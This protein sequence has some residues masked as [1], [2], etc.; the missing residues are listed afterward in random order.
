MLAVITKI[1]P[2]EWERKK[3]HKIVN[4]FLENTRPKL[5]GLKIVLGGSFA[6]DTW[7]SGDHDIDLFVKF[8][9]NLYRKKNLS[10]LLAKRL[11]N[12]NLVHGSRDYFQVQYKGYLFELIPVLDIK[13]QSKAVNITDVSP[14]HALW[15][16][17]NINH[18]ADDIRL[19]KAFAKANNIYGAESYI[20]GFSGYLLEV[21]TIYYKGFFNLLKAASSWKEPEFIDIHAHYK[22]KTHAF[23]DLNKSKLSSL[24]VIDPVQK[25][26]NAAAALSSEKF[27]RFVETCRKFIH[28]PS[29]KFFEQKQ[30][31]IKTLK[32]R[33][34]ANTLLYIELKP[35]EGKKDVIGCKIMKAF[36]LL[37]ERMHSSGFE[38]IDT[39]W[40][41]S[42]EKSKLWFIL[43]DSILPEKRKHYGPRIDDE[44]NK[45]HFIQKWHSHE[46]HEEQGRIHVFVKREHRKA[47]DF[48]KHFLRSPH[49]K[50]CFKKIIKVKIY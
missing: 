40:E 20:Q 48:A 38:F 49:V 33:A 32:D 45:L 7:L 21:L 26:R 31:D 11:S 4:T 25:S 2:S 18:L 41:F 44:K 9:Y 37:K 43:Q 46:I 16:Q 50:D 36:S 35:L 28:F 47:D 24:V 27:H 42:K 13:T 8:P 19:V 1:K 39:G 15:V 3:V 22:N 5:R 30:V 12:Y 34:A 14:L 17:D 10:E 23:R 6:K 29:E